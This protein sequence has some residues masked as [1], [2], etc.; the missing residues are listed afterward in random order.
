MERIKLEELIRMKAKKI[1]QDFI[2]LLFLLVVALAIPAWAQ[3]AEPVPPEVTQYAEDWPLPNHDYGNTRAAT[4]STITS[5]NVMD[6]GVAWSMPITGIGAYGGAASTPLIMGNTVYF[7]DLKSNT[8]SLDLQSGNVN[9][10]QMF[11]DDNYG[12]NGPS[13]GWGKVFVV[14]GHHNISA[15]DAATGEEIWTNMS[16]LS[17]VNTTG[18][19]I[20]PTAYDGMVYVSTVP[21][22]ADINWYSPGGRGIIYALDQET[23]ETAWSFETVPEDLWGHPEINSGGG[24]WYTPAIDISTGAMFWA[25]ANPAPFPGTEEYPN[26]SSRPGPN[27]YTDTMMALDHSTGVMKWFN[28]VYPHDLFDFDLQ[29]A[30]ILAS[31]NISGKQQ[32]IVIGAGKMGKV[33]AF[34]RSSGGLLWVAVVGEH[35]ENDQLDVLPNG[36]TRVR[37]A[38]IGGVETPMAY[39][40]G[41]VYVPV[42]DM[43]TDWTPS[44]LVISTFNFS[45]GKGSLWAVDVNTGKTLWYK[46]FDTINVGGAIV[47]NDLVFT[48][49]NDGTIYAFKRDTG[50]RV[51][52]YKA[53]AG[54][55]G[56]PAAAGDTIIW[57]CGVGGSPELLALRL[58]AERNTPQVMITNPKDGAVLPQGDVTI[59]VDVEN[60]D[61]VER[62]GEQ[63]A[64]GEGH[65][66]YYMD[67]PVPTIPGKP[68]I[69][70][71]GTYAHTAS[72][73]YV[74]RN[75]TP[76]MHN[77]SVQLVNN[78]HTALEMPLTD[79]ITITVTV[80]MVTS[81]GPMYQNAS[82]KM[83]ASAA[84]AMPGPTA[85]AEMNNVTVNL[86]ARNIAFDKS[87]I[88][89]PAGA[90]VTMNFDNQ[91]SVPHNF[92]LYDNSQAENVIFKGEVITGPK[93]IVYTFDAPEEP[94]TYFFRCDIHPTT[95]T[96]QF[97]VV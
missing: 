6:L 71:E 31:A 83:P 52:K 26:G 73:S 12:P 64:A 72:T 36:T 87:T 92:A 44:S 58:G 79:K 16:M 93:T 27:L 69:T 42:I 91:E 96:G 46:K 37:P 94:G 54:I 61:L 77:F 90:N 45:I 86:S 11:R 48:A 59:N 39:A 14:K 35:N 70:A 3:P 29:I 15:L 95:M 28:Q 60:F 40:D 75:V 19:D 50:E 97:I 76:G 41:V 68:A 8:F 9:W 65:L 85:K 2:G 55:N 38:V 53:P 25:I 13:V 21:G 80:P 49:T 30:P 56:W 24:C 67:V 32:E 51:W 17:P 43:F 47:V 18:I 34:N 1:M 82:G 20:Q 66:H 33:Y 62:Q 78:D 84:T 88:T 10:A 4:N 63:K 22:T 7:Q 74:W 57:P 5:E 23:G 89:V 81:T